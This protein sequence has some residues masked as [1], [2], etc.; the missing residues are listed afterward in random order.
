MKVVVV[1]ASLL[2]VATAGA[3]E[4]V[5]PQAPK[6]LPV[7]RAPEVAP[8]VTTEGIVARIFNVEKPWLLVSPLAPKSYGNGGPQTVSYSEND[9]GKPKGFILFGIEFW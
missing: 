3:Q 5:A 8:A 1:F 9:P 6:Q 4:F 7:V 2:L